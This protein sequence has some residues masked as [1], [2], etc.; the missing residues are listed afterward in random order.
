V[1]TEIPPQDRAPIL[2]AWCQIATSGRQHLPVSHG[3]PVSAFEAIAD[4]YLSRSVCAAPAA[5]FYIGS[6]GLNGGSPI[7]VFRS[8]LERGRTNAVH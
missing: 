5:S 4:E 7:G 2:K 6:G 1:L 3:A 8:G